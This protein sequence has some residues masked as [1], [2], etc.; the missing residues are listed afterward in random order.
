MRWH[1]LSVPSQRLLPVCLS[2]FFR[3]IYYVE[4]ENKLIRFTNHSLLSSR[5]RQLVQPIDRAGLLG[6]FTLVLDDYED[7]GFGVW[8]RPRT[9]AK[10]GARCGKKAFA[11][12]SLPTKT[13]VSNAAA[14]ASDWT[15]VE[16]FGQEKL[17]VSLQGR[18]ALATPAAT[19]S[20]PP[21]H[22]YV[23][24]VTSKTQYPGFCYMGSDDFAN[25]LRFET[26]HLH[27]RLKF[28]TRE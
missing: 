14:I 4:Q 10:G 27:A 23:R 15:K 24:V 2:L 21:S 17:S 19:R 22:P 26:E 28:G 5:W 25:I 12:R 16:N 20:F 6:Y 7:L 18:S 3:G 11:S 1:K 9:S 13:E 8:E